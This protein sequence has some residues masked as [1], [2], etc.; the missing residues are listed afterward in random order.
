MTELTG[1]LI[2]QCLDFIPADVMSNPLVKSLN[3]GFE[4]YESRCG[5]Y[6][7]TRENEPDYCNLSAN[8]WKLHISNRDMR[9]I[10]H[11]EVENIEQVRVLIAV[12]KNY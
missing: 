1:E 5:K 8:A 3:T 6:T 7:L 11:C 12:Y 2:R 4:Q 10:A 9:T